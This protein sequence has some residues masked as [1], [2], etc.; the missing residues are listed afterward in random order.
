MKD[1]NGKEIYEGDIVGCPKRGAAFCKCKVVWNETKARIYVVCMGLIATD[2]P[3]PML[4]EDTE[5]KISITGLDY[6]VIG[7]IFD[8][9][10]LLNQ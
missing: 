8:N 2:V 3:F 4:V 5:E 9:P 1:K 10:E 7:N 6:E